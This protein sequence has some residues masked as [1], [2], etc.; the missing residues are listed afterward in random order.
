[1]RVARLFA[2]QA[3]ERCVTLETPAPAGGVT[4]AGDATKITWALSNL[5]ANAL[6]YTP[7]GGRIRIEATPED[8]AVQV[9]VSDN[10]PGI[11]PDQ[12]ERIFE[13]FVQAPTGPT[14][15]RPASGSPSCATSCRRTAAAST[16]RASSAR[17]AA[18][19]SSCRGARRPLAWRPS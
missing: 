2:L 14:P 3:R 9:A 8:G 17:A 6:R 13:R 7:G 1:M 5:I 19:R 18:S 11:P 4:I 15:A 12:R 16:W 10:G